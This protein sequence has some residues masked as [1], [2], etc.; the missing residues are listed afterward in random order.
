MS[1]NFEKEVESAIESMPSSNTTENLSSGDQDQLRQLEALAGMDPEFANSKEYKDLMNSFISER[2]QAEESYDDS[3]RIELSD[4]QVNEIQEMIDFSEI[5]EE[6]KNST[7]FRELMEELE[8]AG[9]LEDVD[10]DQEEEEE[11]IDDIFGIMSNRKQSKDIKLNFEAPKEMIDLIS[12]KFGVSNPETFFNSVDAWRTQA[13]EGSELKKEYEALTS[14][15][16]AM[17]YELRLGIQMWANGDDYNQ[18]FAAGNGRLDFS[19]DF[20]DQDTESLVQHYFAEEFKDLLGEYEDGDITDKEYESRI[21]FLSNSTKRMFAEDKKALE[22]E[23]EDYLNRQKTEFQN[24]KKTALLSVDNL[25]KAYPDFSKSEIN[26]IRNILI[27]GK[28]DNLF[29]KSDGT[30]NDDAAELVAYAMYGKKMLESVKKVA[31][32]SG[33]T[34]ANQRIVDTSPKTMRKQ[35][36]ASPTNMNQ[37]ALGHLSGLF[38]GD[39]YA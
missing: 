26:K 3:G 12:S 37:K 30:Y 20:K 1:D 19:G 28:V 5:D 34:E 23:R 32:R 7:E 16:N 17:P 9:L 24:M 35:K 8:N 31:K 25:S 15:L 11:E 10:D 2:S 4:S 38:K 39:P 21:K 29:V 33:E 13:Q 14:D 22:L 36:S 6:F 18:A 27:E